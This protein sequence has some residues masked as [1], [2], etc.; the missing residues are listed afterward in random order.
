MQSIIF[1]G[2]KLGFRYQK[3][4][5]D[6]ALIFIHGFC[7]D[8]RMWDDFA[9]AFRAPNVRVDLPGFGGSEVPDVHTI[10]YMAEAVGA[11]LD[12]L[13]I[14]KCL[15]V[16]HS[17]GGYVSLELA[18]HHPEKMAGLCLFHSHPFADDSDK[19]QSR[20]KGIEFIRNH[21]HVLYVR[22]LIPKLF[23]F[24]F[25]KGYPFA[26][27]KLIYNATQLAPEGII[28]A[29]E[30]MRDRP[31]RADVLRNLPCPVQFIIGKKDAAVPYETSLRQTLLPDLSDI[32]IF[33]DIG[34]MGMFEATARTTLALDQFRD[35][36]WNRLA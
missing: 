16:G 28:A 19:K 11:I 24:D 5:G 22:Q 6:M 17:M 30:A 23:A 15:V 20:D 10:E 7:E 21:G 2:K 18:R 1:K 13:R 27:N 36:V 32:R 25:N 4:A 8:S 31:D 3:G 29:L 33:A 14:E 26:V 35:F 9:T 34:H 12:H